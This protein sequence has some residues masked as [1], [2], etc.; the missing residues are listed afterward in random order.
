MNTMAILPQL[1]PA[2][3][4]HGL[5]SLALCLCL[6]LCASLTVQAELTNIFVPK[7]VWPGHPGRAVLDLT[8]SGNYAYLFHN[9]NQ[10]YPA[11]DGFIIVDISN[12]E[13]PAP[14]GAY[15]S[16]SEINAIAVDGAYAYA[17]L[18]VD[19]Q[20]WKSLMSAI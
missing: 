3:I 19:L 10:S 11:N 18:G 13:A 8:I 4:L 12:P 15:N 2:R 7:G 14:V 9:G 1:Y 6:T 5:R 17:T 16:T 20:V